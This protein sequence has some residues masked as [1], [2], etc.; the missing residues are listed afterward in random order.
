MTT[1][2]QPDL[3]RSAA[4]ERATDAAID[5]ESGAPVK[6]S[7][8]TSIVRLA[9]AAGVELWHT[10]AGEGYI[11][12]PV[13]HHFEH[14]PLTSRAC[15]DYLTRLYYQNARK[16]PN[17]AA[18]QDAI[19]TISGMARFDGPQHEVHVRVAALESRIYLD[20]CDP[21]WRVVQVGEDGWAVV[22]NPPVRF[23]RPRGVAPLPLPES[24]SIPER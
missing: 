17:A 20:L 9:T 21:E 16:A 24:S 5:A 11:S 6:E 4:L 7:Q 14:Y 1:E 23:R 2:A 22:T 3:D 19:A 12:V 18:L 8:A 13:A 15:R 10:P